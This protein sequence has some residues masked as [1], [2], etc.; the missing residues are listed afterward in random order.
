M[1]CPGRFFLVE[2]V[3]MLYTGRF[4]LIES[5]ILDCNFER[6]VDHFTDLEIEH[7]TNV[8]KVVSFC[9]LPHKAAI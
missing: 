2:S 4:I 1:L 9:L 7:A 8:I 5:V 3:R 6:L